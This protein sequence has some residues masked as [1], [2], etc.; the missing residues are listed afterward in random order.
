MRHEFG[1][2]VAEEPVRQ[3]E[4]AQLAE[5]DQLLERR[6]DL[7]G[8]RAV[9]EPS[10]VRGWGEE[11][12]LACAVVRGRLGVHGSVEGQARGRH[13]AGRGVLD[14]ALLTRAY[15]RG[16][17]AAP[18][19]H[20]GWLDPLRAQVPARHALERLGLGVD[21]RDA[22]AEPG[23]E[24]RLIQ[25]AER[26]EATVRPDLRAVVALRALAPL[27]L[28]VHG[29]GHADLRGE[30]GDDA[31]RHV[32]PARRKAPFELE[33]FEEDSEPEPCRPDLVPEQGVLLCRE[34]PVPREFVRVPVLL[35]RLLPGT[36][37]DWAGPQDTPDGTVTAKR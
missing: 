19:L 5:L 18:P 13:Q 3:A 26:A 33:G 6:R 1:R 21:C 4:G 8:A 31:P 2:R 37:G 34:G 23:E 36:A 29:G 17:Q 10:E 9:L 25:G 16:Q 14:Q 24:L 32:F 30:V 12:D 27:A 20:G 28:R 7:H 35:H 11:G 22:P 15:G